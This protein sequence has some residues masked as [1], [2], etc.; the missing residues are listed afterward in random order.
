MKEYLRSK[1][2]HVISVLGIS[3]LYANT[4]FAG[5]LQDSKIVKGTEKLISDLTTVFMIL[6]AGLTIVLLIAQF[7]KLKLAEDDGDA[8][9][10]KKRMKIITIS[11]VAVFLVSSTF[12]IIL[13]YYR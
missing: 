6:S 13:S 8:K 7:M 10:I 1:I 12:N 11:G 3:F 2:K 5:S 4:A 9:A